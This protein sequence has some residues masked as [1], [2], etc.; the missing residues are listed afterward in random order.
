V[1]CCDP[2]EAFGQV[3]GE[4]KIGVL[5][6]S[7]GR[8]VIASGRGDDDVANLYFAGE[9]SSESDSNNDIVLTELRQLLSDRWSSARRADDRQ[10]FG[11]GRRQDSRKVLIGNPRDR[12]T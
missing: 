1:E 11:S 6:P 9:R 5:N 2:A 4:F 10:C 12:T 7:I 3:G 8:H